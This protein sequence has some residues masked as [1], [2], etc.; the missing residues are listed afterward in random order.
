MNQKLIVGILVVFVFAVA[1]IFGWEKLA[2]NKPSD[3]NLDSQTDTNAQDWKTYQNGKSGFEIKYPTNW[4]ALENSGDNSDR[5]IISLVSPETQEMIQNRKTDS[6]C[7]LS[8]YY[9]FSVADEPENKI[10]EFKATTLEEMIDK[11]R[12]ITRIGQTTLGGEQATDVIWGGAGAYY[13]VLSDH[14]NHLYKISSCN[15]E[16]RNA[17]TKTEMTILESFKFIK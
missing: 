2:I 14:A 1:G 17:L 9:Y 12:M 6:S 15:K 4:M 5:S 16:R 7:D 13:T 10:N 3:T 8:I 11:N